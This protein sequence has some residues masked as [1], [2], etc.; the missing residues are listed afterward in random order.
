RWEANSIGMIHLDSSV[1]IDALTGPRRSQPRLRQLI[2]EGERIVLSSV[3]VFEWRRGPRTREEIADQ[4]ALFPASDSVPF[5]PAEALAA[6][7]CYRKVKRARGREIDIAIAACA[8]VHSAH[9][10]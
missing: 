8:V 1:L 5:G 6:A 10:W 9:L 4:E 3:V 7:D 2:Q